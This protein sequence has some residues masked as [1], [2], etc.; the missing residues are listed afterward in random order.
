MKGSTHLVVSTGI[1]LSISA[2]LDVTLTPAAAAAAI[3]GSL[4]PDLDE[5]NGLLAN[6]TFP[7]PAIRTLQVLLLTAA[8]LAVWL[9]RTQYP[10]NWGAGAVIALSAFA[11][12][13]WLRQLLM[14]IVGGAL[15]IGGTVYDTRR[16][17]AGITLVICALVPHRGFTH[18][19]YAAGLWCA[20]LYWMAPQS[21]AVPIAGGLSYLLHLL[22]DALSKR[23][24]QPLPPLPWKLRIPLMRSGKLSAAVVE[25][26]AIGV[27]F[28]LAWIVFAQMGG[29]KQWIT[30]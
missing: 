14:L 24:I 21:P 18:T 25:T 13:R 5:P 27:T 9:T 10:W 19:L 8:G 20:A 4:L 6:R 11:S 23:G 2:L 16:T 28:I 7:K 30:P 12:T 22:A 17:A 1:S 26:S 3:V 29:W 15:T